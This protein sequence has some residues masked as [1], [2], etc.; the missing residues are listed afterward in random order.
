MRYPTWILALFSREGLL[1]SAIVGFIAR[2]AIPIYR[3]S[4]P[5]VEIYVNGTVT[6]LTTQLTDHDG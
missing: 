4:R 1:E 6:E 3:T 5:F 2:Q